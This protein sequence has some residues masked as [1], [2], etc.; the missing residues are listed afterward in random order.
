MDASGDI[1]H[2]LQ[3]REALRDLIGNYCRAADDCDVAR[4]AELFHPEGLVDSGV[5]RAKPTEFAEQ[6]VAWLHE[7][8]EYVFHAICGAQFEVSGEQATGDIQVVALCQMNAAHGGNRIIA[9]GRYYDKYVM[10]DGIWLIGERI[11]KSNL[12]W[13]FAPSTG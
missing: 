7:H 3:T 5:I 12:S 1:I 6:F 4:L 13:N 8:T 9:A 10:L 2:V 11:F